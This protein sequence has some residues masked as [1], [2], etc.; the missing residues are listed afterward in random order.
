ME[1]D[2]HRKQLGWGLGLEQK[3][4]KMFQKEKPGAEALFTFITL[5]EEGC[6]H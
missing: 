6:R 2:F 1:R 5:S 4:R 3:M